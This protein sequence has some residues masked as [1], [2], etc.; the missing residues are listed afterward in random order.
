MYVYKFYSNHI[1]IEPVV[2]S[3]MSVIH[4]Y[5][6]CRVSY[7]N[8]IRLPI[9]HIYQ[10]DSIRK[11]GRKSNP[12]AFFTMY[13]YCNMNMF[14]TFLL[15]LFLQLTCFEVVIGLYGEVLG[16]VLLTFLTV[17]F[18]FKYFFLY[19]CASQSPFL[20]LSFAPPIFFILFFYVN[21]LFHHPFDLFRSMHFLVYFALSSLFC[22]ILFVFFY[23][24][25]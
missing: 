10:K 12:D 7:K 2:E 18:Y 16:G 14:I 24:L 4:F 9:T 23:I 19:P 3:G 13:Q 20:C 6:G 11:V 5:F 8:D 22:N 21:P 17:Y 15:D 25:V 1:Y